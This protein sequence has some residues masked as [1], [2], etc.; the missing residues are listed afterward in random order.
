MSANNDD[1]ERIKRSLEVFYS[2]D[3]FCDEDDYEDEVR[4]RFTED[5]NDFE[6]I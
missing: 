2:D 6:G 5:I 3:Y 4:R 1:E